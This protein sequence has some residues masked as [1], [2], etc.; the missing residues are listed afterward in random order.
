MIVNEIT[1][2]STTTQQVN[3]TPFDIY[4]TI[5]QRVESL[6]SAGNLIEESDISVPLESS[7]YAEPTVPMEYITTNEQQA[8]TENN[9]P[10]NDNHTHKSSS[11]NEPMSA[12]TSADLPSTRSL[13]TPF[14][15]QRKSSHILVFNEKLSEWR[16]SLLKNRRDK[17]AYYL[18]WR[19]YRP[20]H[21]R[22]SNLRATKMLSSQK[23]LIRGK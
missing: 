14:I 22:I 17:T 4:L 16:Q 20:F 6:A 3:S 23:K 8:P 7:A 21:L 1:Q 2:Y 13:A 12:T 9:L 18:A 19:L 5:K 11:E 10:E 15:D